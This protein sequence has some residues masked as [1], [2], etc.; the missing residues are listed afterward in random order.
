MARLNISVSHN[1][2]SVD[3]MQHKIEWRKSVHV[4]QKWPINGLFQN[5]GITA[6]FADPVNFYLQLIR[7]KVDLYAVQVADK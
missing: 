3:V 6:R 1:G 5:V 7:P 2:E 4:A